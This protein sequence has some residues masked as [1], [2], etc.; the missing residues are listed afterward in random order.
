MVKSIRN[1]DTAADL[2]DPAAWRQAQAALALPLAEAAAALARL[3]ATLVS[4]DAAAAD[5]A[6]LRLALAEAEAMLWAGGI[7]MPREEIG[8][9][10]LDARAASDPEAMRLARWALRRL[11]GRGRLRTCRVS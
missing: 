10:A 4:L 1:R 8:R 11:G 9:D 6:V 3:D 2:A 7:V 5:G